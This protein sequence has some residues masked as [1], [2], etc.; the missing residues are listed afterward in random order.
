M[1]LDTV[2]EQGPDRATSSQLILN[3]AEGRTPIS[4]IEDTD[5]KTWPLFLESVS[6]HPAV[7]S[8]CRA[9][10]LQVDPAG[11]RYAVGHQRNRDQA[12]GFS[13]RFDATL[14]S[15]FLSLIEQ[16][17]D[18][19]K[20]REEHDEIMATRPPPTPPPEEEG[21]H[22]GRGGGGSNDDGDD[23]QGGDED[24][25]NN[26]GEG[27]EESG[28]GAAAAPAPRP[29]KTRAQRKAEEQQ[30][31]EDRKRQFEVEKKEHA[32]ACLEQKL[33]NAVEADAI[34]V[35]LVPV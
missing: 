13:N 11:V 18:A 31:K 5:A 34:K 28:G 10:D 12:G 15:A 32:V 8:A 26:G 4:V 23:E 27:D 14:F 6:T 1:S 24:E 20:A 30:R 35:T 22:H 29:R 9:S 33:A 21:G 25:H 3:F 7:V 19:K 2:F 17:K 16:R